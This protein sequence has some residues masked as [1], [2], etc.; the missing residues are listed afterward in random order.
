[1]GVSKT[2]TIG[3]NAVVLGQAGVTNTLEGNMVY[4]GFPAED[5]RV[6]RREYVW[7]KRIPALWKKIM[8]D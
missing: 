5:A 3:E 1:M 7:M 4:M 6:K 2:L 8:E